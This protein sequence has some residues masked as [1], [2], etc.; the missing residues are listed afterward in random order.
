MCEMP[1]WKREAD[2][3][4]KALAVLA[5]DVEEFE[6]QRKAKTDKLY[7]AEVDNDGHTKSSAFVAKNLK[8]ARVQAKTRYGTTLQKVREA[9]TDERE[10]FK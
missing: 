1:R 3:L 9:T 4:N 8:D 5:P 10:K 2:N 7:V 6:A